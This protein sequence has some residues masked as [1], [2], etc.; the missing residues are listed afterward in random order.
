MAATRYHDETYFR[1]IIAIK[2]SYRF[3]G[4]KLSKHGHYKK[5][6]YTRY[7][8]FY[9]IRQKELSYFTTDENLIYFTDLMKKIGLQKYEST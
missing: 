4:F 3:W 5:K 7:I 6:P 8:T 1:S 9:R 2:M